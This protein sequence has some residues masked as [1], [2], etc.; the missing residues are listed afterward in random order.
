MNWKLLRWT[1]FIHL[2]CWFNGVLIKSKQP[3]YW[4]NVL[5]FHKLNKLFCCHWKKDPLGERYEIRIKTFLMRSWIYHTYT[6]T[7]AC[8]FIFPWMLSQF[9]DAQSIVN[10]LVK[11]LIYF[12]QPKTASTDSYL[13]ESINCSVHSAQHQRVSKMILVSTVWCHQFKINSN[14]LWILPLNSEAHSRVWFLGSVSFEYKIDLIRATFSNLFLRKRP[15][16]KFY[17]ARKFNPF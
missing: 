14:T 6:H 15:S 16:A 7:R 1:I 17:R 11:L 10:L 5:S 8:I 13:G 12:C 2:L 9:P 3:L 4:F